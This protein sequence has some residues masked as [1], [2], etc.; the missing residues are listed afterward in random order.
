MKAAPDPKDIQEFQFK[1]SH[2]SQVLNAFTS[3]PTACSLITADKKR[4]LLY[5]GQS[6]RIIVLKPGEDSDPEWK[7]E[8]DTLV[9]ISKLTLS[10]DCSYLA[11]APHGPCILIYDVQALTK[12]NLQLL[13]EIRISKSNSEVF[14][15]DVQWNPT[16]PGM[17][18]TVGSDY[19]IGSFQIK[20]EKIIE[21]KGLEQ[22]NGVDALCAAWSPK[23]K[24][25]VVGCRNGS[26]IQLK[27][28]LKIARTIPGPAPYIGE[29]ISILWISNYQF[30]ATYFDNEQRIN[31]LIIDAPKG[32]TNAIF[33]CYEDITYG[34]T[35]SEGG[36]TIP[37]Y[38]FDYVPEWGLIIAASSN[39]SEIAVLGS[40]DGG[41]TWNQWQ[42]VDSGRAELP[43]ICT[44]ESYPVGLAID[45][46]SVRKLPWGADSFLPHPVPILH[47]LSTA[48]QLCSFHM[49]NL[50]PN[51]PDINSPPTE[52]V[53]SPPQPQLNTVPLDTSLIMNGAI[54]ST[55]C[56]K[57]S[58]SELKRTK[59]IS[60]GNIYDK[61]L[62]GSGF[63]VQPSVEKPKQQEQQIESP[64]LEVKVEPPK[65]THLQEPVQPDIKQTSV[66]ETISQEP[67]E[68]KTTVEDESRDIRAYIEEYN[69][70]ERELCNRLELHS[71]ECGT[72]EERRKLIDTSIIIDQFL[73][74]L[75]ETTNS[76]S[77][78]IAYLKALLLQSFAWVEETKSKNAASV[79]FTTRNCGDSNKVSD[80]QKLYYYTQM[81]LAQ[82]TKILDLEW[83]DHK[84]QEMSRMKIP[85]MEFVYQ[86]LILHNKIIQKEKGKVEQLKKQWKLLTRN[87]NI[88]GLNHSL[89]NLSISS[90]KSSVSLPRNAGIIEARCKTIASRT[91]NFTEGKQI[92]LREHLSSSTPRIIKPVNP[93][94]I[95]DRL[96][97]TLSALASLNTTP[98]ETKNKVE[99]PVSKLTPVTTKQTVEK[100]K[101]QSPLASL[102]SIVAR[103]G[104]SEPNNV[105]IQTKAQTKQ[106]TFNV[107]FPATTGIKLPQTEKKSSPPVSITIPQITKSKET[108]TFVQVSPSAH[109]V[110]GLMKCFPKVDPITFGTVTQK[111]EET[112]VQKPVSKESGAKPSKEIVSS[113]DSFNVGET[114]LFGT[115]TLKDALSTDTVSG[116]IQG[117]L[118]N[119]SLQ[120]GLTATT[121]AR[122]E[123]TTPFS[124]A[125]PITVPGTVKSASQAGMP[126]TTT[127]QT[128][129]FASKPSST[130]SPFNLKIPSTVTTPQA[131][132]S[133]NLTGLFPGLQ[134]SNQPVGSSSNLSSEGKLNY[135][136]TFGTPGFP[137]SL[138]QMSIGLANEALTKGNITTAASVIIEKVPSI[139]SKVPSF[140]SSPIQA[141][142]STT[143]AAPL[144][145]N[146]TNTSNVSI[147]GGMSTSTP[148]TSTFTVTTSSTGFGIQSTTTSP[149]A[150]F[151][152]FKN[153]PTTTTTTTTTI[154]TTSTTGS[155]FQ[156]SLSKS[157]FGEAA[158][159]LSS[160]SPVSSSNSTP[161]TLTFGSPTTTSVASVFGKPSSPTLNTQF[162]S[163]PAV[164]SA[165]NT[166]EKPIISPASVHF[167]STIN[168]SIFSGMPTTSANTSIFSGSNT[169]S[170]FDSNTQVSSATP[171]FGGSAP[172]VNTFGTPQKS[173]F[174]NT[175]ESGSIFSGTP[176]AGS[177]A[178]FGGTA[179]NATSGASS[180]GSAPAFGTSTS[181]IGLEQPV[182]GAQPGFGQAPAFEPKPVFGSTPRFGSSKPAFSSGFGTTAFGT[183]AAPPAF[184]SPPAMGGNASSMDNNMSKVFGSVGGNN[185]F[186]TLASQ[187]GGLSFSSLAQK[188]PEAEKPPT[189]SGGSSFSSWR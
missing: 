105:P 140:S 56:L 3:I 175:Q 123:P 165:A 73:R 82:A 109:N 122:P 143:S 85:H 6:S 127:A 22:L 144:F 23:G 159:N 130:T 169:N 1:Q 81:Q 166:F 16:V 33:T 25:V 67:V 124:F 181:P 158:T 157:T 95:Q 91:L 59:P 185:T 38:Y 11:I 142:A 139:E 183:T 104:T 29:I 107:T 4:G 151:G 47:I 48:G 45:K 51:C 177:T 69:L 160:A 41:A 110:P 72:E 42:L 8:I 14:V 80:L 52:I 31:V 98:G 24:Q 70:F 58:V 171:I 27:P 63:F 86:N 20:D 2:I 182:T 61:F 150:I 43:L 74:E 167:G 108:I 187:T 60:T 118:L 15:N 148:S 46:S 17:F 180:P 133:L 149:M 137:T 92:K 71:W 138:G 77:S 134:T 111:P 53:T 76:L 99:S 184:G 97:A 131:Q 7:I 113:S 90:S 102:N 32:G 96:E 100:P 176:N 75:R 36:G 19:T 103:I 189:F 152:G 155:P 37:R 18:C 161:S 44:T 12:G 87:S 39:S 135:K 164:S 120:F 179:N 112:T 136:P 170:I 50:T 35:N 121:T 34:I 172:P 5:I 54:T 64:S 154:A 126:Q 101:Q 62:K 9:A 78:D 129:S 168:T 49:V 186:E 128:F 147:F 116:K 68:Q 40:T 93:S 84:S 174:N 66:T 106:P 10:C 79:D 163:T 132:E 94:P 13:H 125:T 188:S 146:Q 21:L 162:Q 141:A 57:Q 89:S 153:A 115:G 26:L 145:S 119:T 178:F 83:S 30:C 28:D 65:E 88:F 117:N 55:P 156:A 173:I 114:N